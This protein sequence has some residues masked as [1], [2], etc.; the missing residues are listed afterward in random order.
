MESHHL[1]F[2]SAFDVA[3]DYRLTVITESLKLLS[4]D[5]SFIAAALPLAKAKL[6]NIDHNNVT[7]DS[8]SEFISYKLPSNDAQFTA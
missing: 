8:I 4:K 7:A 3:P 6:K 1:I 5:L 2:Y